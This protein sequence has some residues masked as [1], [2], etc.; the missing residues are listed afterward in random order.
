MI[1]TLKPGRSQAAKAEAGA[2]VRATVEAILGDVAERGDAAVRHYSET[3]DG[4]S[5]PSFRLSAGE[6]AA[7]EHGG[8]AGGSGDNGLAGNQQAE[9]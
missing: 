7:C 4:W 5:P 9:R 3:L 8:Q 2:E 6:V 1:R